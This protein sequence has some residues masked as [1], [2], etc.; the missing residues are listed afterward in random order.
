MNFS[1]HLMVEYGIFHNLRSKRGFLLFL[2]EWVG[3]VKLYQSR[4]STDVKDVKNFTTVGYL[5]AVS[6]IFGALAGGALLLMLIL[7]ITECC[8]HSSG[9]GCIMCIL[10]ASFMG[11]KKQNFVIFS[12]HKDQN[13]HIF[14]FLVEHCL[15]GLSG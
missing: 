7:T 13:V 3:E 12:S 1:R 11:K 9:A 4:N 8:S 2:L 10:W 5:A 14:A 15:L 6:F